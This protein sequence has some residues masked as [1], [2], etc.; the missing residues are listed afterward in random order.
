MKLLLIAALALSLHAHE[1]TVIY[2][3]SFPGSVPPYFKITVDAEGKTVYVEAPDDPQPLSFTLEPAERDAIF[4][5]AQKLGFFDRK[6]ESDLPVARMGDKTFRYENGST[7]REQKFNYSTDPDAQA[8]AD[9]FERISE[10]ERYLIELERAARFD[11]L[12]VNKAI[13]LLQAAWERKR[14][15]APSQYL[16][17]LDRIVKNE[18]YLNMARDR[19]ARLADEFRNPPQAHAPNPESKQ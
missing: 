10:S 9:W 8:L 15:V 19:A 3:K 12:G 4:T 18:S 11:K 16:K 2:S 7:A 17:W 1:G 13:L 6:I 14:L 5:L